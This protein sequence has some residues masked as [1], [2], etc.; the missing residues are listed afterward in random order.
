M[1]HAS[2]SS[3]VLALS[4]GVVSPALVAELMATAR[5]AY[6]LSPGQLSAAVLAIALSP[7]TPGTEREEPLARVP[8]AADEA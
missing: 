1:R 3:S 4:I 2:P 8:V 7:V 5:V 6:R